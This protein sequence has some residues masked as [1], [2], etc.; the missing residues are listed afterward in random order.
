MWREPLDELIEDLERALPAETRPGS[1]LLEDLQVV[2]S[3]TLYGRTT[4]EAERERDPRYQQANE[5]VKR[6]FRQLHEG[7]SGS[8][9]PTA[10]HQNHP[11]SKID[12]RSAL[13]PKVSTAHSQAAGG[14]QAIEPT[15]CPCGADEDS[16]HVPD[17]PLAYES[18]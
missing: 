10:D 9:E 14:D 11:E 3:A 18:P 5:R 16:E 2:V 17:C 7:P 15:C 8:R 1:T 12:G 4:T 13:V 6:H